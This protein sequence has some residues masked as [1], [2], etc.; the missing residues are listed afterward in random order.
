MEVEKEY[1]SRISYAEE[2]CGY[3]VIGRVQVYY[4]DEKL[5]EIIAGGKPYLLGKYVGNNMEFALATKDELVQKVTIYP[6]P[7]AIY[8]E[9]VEECVW[10][11]A[12]Y[13]KEIVKPSDV[14]YSIWKRKYY[15]A[16]PERKETLVNS[17]KSDDTK[18]KEPQTKHSAEKNGKKGF[19][20]TDKIIAFCIIVFFLALVIWAVWSKSQKES[21]Q[22]RTYQ[23]ESIIES[24]NI[25]ESGEEENIAEQITKQLDQLT[26]AINA[27]PEPNENNVSRCGDKVKVLQWEVI[28]IPED[29]PNAERLKK[30]QRRAVETFVNAKNRYIKKLEKYD[31]YAGVYYD[32]VEGYLLDEE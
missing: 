14:G 29:N 4:K 1:C 17:A 6:Q 15:F 13:S 31:E 32:E 5:H 23:T 28:D 24:D 16:L 2:Y 19:S 27:L 7:K 18:E 11:N 30:S 8:P 25:V 21:R 20:K 9:D 22:E 10:V 26:E 12:E 3:E